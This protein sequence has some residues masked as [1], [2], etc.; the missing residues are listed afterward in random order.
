MTDRTQQVYVIQGRA[1]VGDVTLN[2]GDYLWTPP[3]GVHDLKAEE[4]TLLFV[5]TPNGVRVLE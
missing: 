4:D 2:A 5:T 3:H 1:V